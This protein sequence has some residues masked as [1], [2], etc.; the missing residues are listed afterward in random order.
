[1]ARGFKSRAEGAE[2]ARIALEHAVRRWEAELENDR[3]LS[4]RENGLLAFVGAVLGLSL[5]KLELLAAPNPSGWFWTVRGLVGTSLILLLGALAKFL[6]TPEADSGIE[7]GTQGSRTEPIALSSEFLRWPEQPDR[8]YSGLKDLRAATLEACEL[9]TRAATSLHIKNLDR[10]R[11]ID[12]GE[13]LLLCAAVLAALAFT[14]YVWS[15]A[16]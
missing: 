2:P 15:H 1:M 3:K 10:V 6:L 8:P 4:Q 14:C 9:T 5:F 7:P 12:R 16:R 13:M 11:A